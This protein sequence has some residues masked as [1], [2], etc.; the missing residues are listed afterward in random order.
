MLVAAHWTSLADTP[1][2][3]LM[4]AEGW[5]DLL[6]DHSENTGDAS[7]E[8]RMAG[9][10]IPDGPIAPERL[11]PVVAFGLTASSIGPA[12]TPIIDATSNG[13]SLTTI[14]VPIT[15]PTGAVIDAIDLGI[16]VDNQRMADLTAD[17]IDCL[18][19]SPLTLPAL[20]GYLYLAAR[21]DCAGRPF[22]PP[23]SWGFR[24]FDAVVGNDI[25]YVGQTP[26]VAYPIVVATYHGGD[27]LPYAPT[28]TYVSSP[29]AI[30]GATAWGAIALTAE[31]FGATLT[32]EVRTAADEAALAT[33]EWIPVADQEV[34]RGRPSELL[35]YRLTVAGTGWERAT[36][37]RVEIRYRVTP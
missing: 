13:P 23:L 1:T 35:Q 32:F 5:H 4:L 36:I 12:A 10:G 15:G 27:R 34:P 25:L 14:P 17:V 18:G 31:L 11:R 19:S 37:D 6:L 8:L 20:P 30:S 22:S 26:S 28:M 29:R 33:A 7:V 21:T 16:G 2:A 9:P 24:V 3:T